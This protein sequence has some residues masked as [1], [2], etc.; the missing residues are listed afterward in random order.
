MSKLYAIAAV[1]LLA[2]TVSAVAVTTSHV[3]ANPASGE[4]SA[5]YHETQAKKQRK[6]SPKNPPTG[7]FS[8]E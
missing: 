2:V 1:S 8:S 7:S 5:D 6:S 4:I 3:A